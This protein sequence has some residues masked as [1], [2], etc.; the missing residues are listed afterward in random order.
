MLTE[1]HF[2]NPSSALLPPTHIHLLS[3]HSKLA[4]L[5][6]DYWQTGRHIRRRV[7]D[8]SD[9]KLSISLTSLS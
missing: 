8:L 2:Y 5:H 6:C 3:R 4:V 1:L 7:I 9:F